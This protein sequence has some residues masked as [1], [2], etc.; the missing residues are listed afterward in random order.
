MSLCDSTRPCCPEPIGI[1]SRDFHAGYNQAE[2]DHD[3]AGRFLG[4]DPV[5]PD[6]LRAGYDQAV[7]DHAAT[8]FYCRKFRADPY[9]KTS[10]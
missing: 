5:A 2:I 1:E 8:G 3:T 7:N 4:L 9:R 6:A 10:S